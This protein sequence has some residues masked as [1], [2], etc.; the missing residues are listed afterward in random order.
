MYV[1]DER[2]CSKYV[3]YYYNL[4]I[5]K[6]NLIFLKKAKNLKRHFMKEDIYMANKHMNKFSPLA[7]I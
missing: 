5:K 2:L 1:S 7:V 6:T 3:N 4:I